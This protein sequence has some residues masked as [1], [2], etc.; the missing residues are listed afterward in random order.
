M[1][2]GQNDA[3]RIEQTLAQVFQKKGYQ[4]EAVTTRTP[5]S[6]LLAQEDT[7]DVQSERLETLR[8]LNRFYVADG[9]HPGSVLR[10]VFAVLKAVSP[11]LIVNMTL[12]EMGQMFGETKAAQSW[13]VKK[14]F[15]NYQRERGIKGF[16]A[17]F[18]KSEKA[19]S[20]YSRAQQGNTNRAGKKPGAHV[21]RYNE[22]AA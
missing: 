16:K 13:R 5:L 19:R 1:S 7:A 22:N 15:T 6:D 20:A 8:A 14:I 2:R 17:A 4:Q 10:R 12:A 3:Q 18:Q 9:P 11:E 21:R